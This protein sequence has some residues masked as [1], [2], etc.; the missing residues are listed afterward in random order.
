MSKQLGIPK[1]TRD[2][3]PEK[4]IKRNFIFNTLRSVFEKFGYQPIETPSF[5]NLSTLTGKYGEEGDRLIFKLLNSGNYLKGS[6]LTNTRPELY[7]KDA[8]QLEKDELIELNQHTASLSEKALRYDLTVPF[9]RYVVMHQNDIQFPFKRYQIQ[10]V[11]RADRP[12]KG[13]YREFF[14]CDVDIIGSNS[15]INEVELINIFDEALSL[16]GLKDFTVK[17][18]NRKILAGLVESVGATDKFT[19]ITIALDKYDKIGADGVKNELVKAGLVEEAINKLINILSFN[20]SAK[21]KLDNLK[22]VLSS[23]ETGMKGIQEMEFIFSA[24]ENIN[25]K[26]ANIDLDIKL[27]RGL[28]YYTGCIFEVLAG[29][30]SIGSIC[31]GGR[32]DDLTGIFGLS[33]VSGVGVSFGADRIYDVME[34]LQL[35]NNIETQASTLLICPLDEDSQLHALGLLQSIRESGISAEI[36]PDTAKIKKQMKYAG[37]RGVLY[38]ILIGS[39]EVEEKRYTLKDMQTG[40]QVQLSIESII[41]KIK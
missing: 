27:A 1:G 4:V 29:G 6:S 16:L 9:A 31:G 7:T 37:N 14:Q 2:H 13:R 18:N 30:V 21:E 35:F 22:S 39:Q 19:A 3:S 12:Q 32:Y 36:Y 20:G 23:S 33:D 17:L 24:L 38:T 40:E 26:N 25:I 8:G 15:L 11:W 28:N 10:P 41:E 5:E 34:E